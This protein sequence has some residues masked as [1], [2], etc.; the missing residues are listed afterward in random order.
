MELF[1]TYVKSISVQMRTQIC[2]SMQ[3]TEGPLALETLNTGDVVS[4]AA[5]D[6]SHGHGVTVAINGLGKLIVNGPNGW[7]A[8]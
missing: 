3:S 7:K 5:K 4:I 6:H 1:V 2:T 8:R